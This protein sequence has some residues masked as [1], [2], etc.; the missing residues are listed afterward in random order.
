MKNANEFRLEAGPG[1]VHWGFLDAQ[2]SPCHTLE[3]GDCISI[4]TVSG[5]ADQMPGPPFVIPESLR[6][7]QRDV[8]RK[9]GTGHICTGPVAVKGARAGQT[10]QVDIEKIDLH[11]DWGYNVIRPLGGALPDEF[12]EKRLIHIPLDR[13]SMTGRLPWGMEVPLRPFFGVL[14][15]APPP[16]WGTVSTIPPRRNGGNMDNRELIAGT[17]LYLPIFVDGALF[18]AGDGHAAQGDGEVC[19]SAIETELIGRFRLTVRNDMRLSWPMAETPVHIMTMGFDPD[20][21]RCVEIALRQMIDLI[22][23][24]TGIDRYEAFTLCSVA[25]DLRVTQVVN[26]NKGVHFLL[27]RHY[28]D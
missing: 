19:I 14:A 6:A 7:I 2:L 4:S 17:R 21:D 11:Y 24:R 9:L 28:L 5:A 27:D 18:S 25:A 16:N 1:T 3:L 12:H 13:D 22:C 20:L 10:L 15:V 23:E 26:G 8:V